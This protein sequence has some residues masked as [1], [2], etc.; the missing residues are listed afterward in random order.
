M[1][2]KKDLHFLFTNIKDGDCIGFYDKGIF[3]DHFIKLLTSSQI[4]HVGTVYNVDR[5]D[6]TIYFYFSEQCQR[7]GQYT[8]C[9]MTKI[10]SKYRI[11]FG[12]KGLKYTKMFY[13]QLKTPL[14]QDG[15]ISGINDA[16]GQV[17]KK[18]SF[19]SL[20]LTL[21]YIYNIMP[22]YFKKFLLTND[23]SLGRVCSTHCLMNAVANGSI[24]YSMIQDKYTTPKEYMLYG[25]LNVYKINI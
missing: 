13:G 12:R 16:M 17:G 10:K 20:P 3:I 21:D 23:K 18:Y 24:N 19:I 5:H 4:T 8:L 25:H 22:R 11:T 1:F 9:K 6:N 15:S 7:G 14:T 2:I